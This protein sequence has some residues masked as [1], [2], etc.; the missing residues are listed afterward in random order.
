MVS[1]FQQKLSGQSKIIAC[2]MVHLL[3]S[4]APY[5]ATYAGRTSTLAHAELYYIGD[6][7]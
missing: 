5:K 3:G 6:H 2:S 4:G 1:R 7:G